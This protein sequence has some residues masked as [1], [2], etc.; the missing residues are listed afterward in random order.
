MSLALRTPAFAVTLQNKTMDR[1]ASH[2]GF[3]PILCSLAMALMMLTIV[4]G[5]EVVTGS[6]ARPI[7]LMNSTL[8]GRK[9]SVCALQTCRTRLFRRYCSISRVGFCPQR[10]RPKA[11]KCCYTG[12]CEPGH[13]FLS[14]IVGEFW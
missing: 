5:Q 1:N 14:G 11:T 4:E 10:N 6:T 2:P 8:G 7:T 12:C 9:V 13:S 3:W